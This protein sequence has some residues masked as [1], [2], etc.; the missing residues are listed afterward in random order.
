MRVYIMHCCSKASSHSSFGKKI[1]EKSL[2]CPWL[3]FLHFF[4]K[5][6]SLL[7][8]GYNSLIFLICHP[9]SFF[10]LLLLHWSPYKLS[11]GLPHSLITS[12]PF[13]YRN[14]EFIF[15]EARGE[16]SVLIRFLQWF[17][18]DYKIKSP[19]HKS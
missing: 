9:L 15:I 19:C 11:P 12:L 7:I 8:P 1:F 10:L 17:F 14:C 13:E 16:F 18:A 3:I 4:W 2:L 5:H 6:S